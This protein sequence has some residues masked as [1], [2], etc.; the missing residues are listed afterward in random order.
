MGRLFTFT[1]M[2]MTLLLGIKM[3]AH[4]QS[5]EEFIPAPMQQTLRKAKRLIDLSRSDSAL[6]HLSPLVQRIEEQKLTYTAFFLEA[7]LNLGIAYAEGNR[8]VQAMRILN[9]VKDKSRT[10]GYWRTYAKACLG[11]ARLQ[12]KLQ[13]PNQA[14][15]NLDD[16]RMAIVQNGLNTTYPALAIGSAS[17]HYNFGYPDSVRYFALEAIGASRKFNFPILLADGYSLMGLFAEENQVQKAI[18]YHQQSAHIFREVHNFKRLSEEY[19]HVVQLY[20]KFPDFLNGMLYVDSS[21]VTAY[22]SIAVGDEKNATLHEAY[23]VKGAIFNH[24]GRLDSALFYTNRGWSQMVMF[25]QLQDH[26]RAVEVDEKYKDEQRTQ[27][28]KTQAQLLVLERQRFRGALI[29]TG[30]ILFFTSILVYYYLRLQ[31]ANRI[32]REQTKTILETNDKLSHSLDQQITLQG[33]IHHR[34]KNNLQLI[35]SLLELQKEEIKDENTRN[36]LEAM[37][38]RIYAI[39]AVHDVLYQGHEGQLINFLDYTNKLCLHLQQAMAK[40]DS[41]FKLKIPEQ[42]FNLD[43]LIPLGIMLNELITNSFKYGF[44]KNNPVRIDIQLKPEPNGFYL[45]YKDNGPGFPDGHLQG[46]EGGLGAY[47]IRSMARQLRGQVESQN[48]GGASY[49]IFFQ[50]KN[51]TNLAQV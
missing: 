34:V 42:L 44:Q 32:T 15:T 50:E 18:K 41:I 12:Q 1:F 28:L 45:N 14:K 46:R 24:L 48:D 29:M 10:K 19:M 6:Y 22:Q 20:L 35:I 17:W 4:A 5:P 43:T 37:S 30:V 9:A 36:G 40:E 47:L 8:N 21:I 2:S 49:T 31:K 27:Q 23:Q 3:S 16:A 39:A 38:S 7:N 25:M 26:D 51:A 11:L 13:R 33:E